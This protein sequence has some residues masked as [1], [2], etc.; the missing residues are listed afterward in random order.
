[1]FYEKIQATKA[2]APVDSALPA[3]A[4]Q[5]RPS[6]A[7]AALYQFLPSGKHVGF[8]RYRYGGNGSYRA[9]GRRGEAGGYRGGVS[10]T[11]QI[12]L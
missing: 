5:Q 12:R 7:A 4:G 11:K 3:P 8:K 9:A 6:P 1:M 2:A 10:G